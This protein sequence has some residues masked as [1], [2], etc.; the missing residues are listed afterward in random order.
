MGCKPLGIKNMSL[1]KYPFFCWVWNVA[2]GC[3]LMHTDDGWR[4]V[5]NPLCS[6]WDSPWSERLL[7]QYNPWRNDDYDYKDG[8][9]DSFECGFIPGVGCGLAGTEDCDW[10]CPF[11]KDLI[12]NVNYPDCGIPETYPCKA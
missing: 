12:A 5:P 1:L 4:W 11:R 6:D 7:E 3:Y 9:D 2:N 8:C 10:E